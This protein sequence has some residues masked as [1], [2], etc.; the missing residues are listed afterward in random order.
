MPSGG[1]RPC[2]N[3]ARASARGGAETAWRGRQGGHV[4]SATAFHS[5]ALLR[6]PA[7][8]LWA[9]PRPAILGRARSSSIA[10]RTI[11]VVPS[12]SRLRRLSFGEGGYACSAPPW[13]GLSAALRARADRCTIVLCLLDLRVRHAR[14]ARES[15]RDL[16][17]VAGSSSLPAPTD[18]GPPPVSDVRNV[19]AWGGRGK[20]RKEIGGEEEAQKISPRY[21]RAKARFAGKSGREIPRL[22]L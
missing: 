16:E 22:S 6:E 19:S 11:R 21:P 2:F 9:P 13:A 15:R 14:P 5:G 12:L 10:W 3:K 18:A 7:S 4:G 8:G 20:A 1:I 17:G